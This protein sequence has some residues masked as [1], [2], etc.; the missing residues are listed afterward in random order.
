MV[1]L[2]ADIFQF[3][4]LIAQQ[5]V[6]PVGLAPAR[7]ASADHA[8]R[9]AARPSV[10]MKLLYK[11]AISKSQCL[12]APHHGGET[13]GIGLD[14]NEEITSLPQCNRYAGRVRNGN[15]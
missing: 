10:I 9:S 7:P 11:T 1:C 15:W 8:A 13:T 14:M 12:P 3:V 5:C 6:F 4:H 2:K